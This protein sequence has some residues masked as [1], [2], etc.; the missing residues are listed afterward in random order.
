MR[1]IFPNPANTEEYDQHLAAEYQRL[2]GLAGASAQPA[3][4]KEIRG[5]AEGARQ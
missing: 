4:P 5:V 1:K 3:A 2:M